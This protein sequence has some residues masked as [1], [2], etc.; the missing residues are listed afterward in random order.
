MSKVDAPAAGE[1]GEQSIPQLQSDTVQSDSDAEPEPEDAAE[2]APTVV[3]PAHDNSDEELRRLAVSRLSKHL[4]VAS[5]LVTRCEAMAKVRRGDRLGPIYAAARLMR[6][7]AQV[8]KA[9]AQVALLE[10]RHRSIIE[11][12]QPPASKSPEL[13][14]SLQSRGERC[15]EA[16][17]VWHRLGEIVEETVRFRQGESGARD[18]VADLIR[19]E[20]ETLAKIHD[21]KASPA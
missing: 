13:N 7:D 4:D 14:W 12:V 20:E 17:K 5:G 3:D 15:E 21:R 9:L 2:P 8:A 11:R 6:A 16:L 18:V 1:G 19:R 10:T